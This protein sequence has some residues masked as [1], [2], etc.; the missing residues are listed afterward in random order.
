MFASYVDAV[1]T[2]VR[3]QLQGE[4]NPQCPKHSPH[5]NPPTDRRP[6]PPRS[7]SRRSASALRASRRSRAASRPRASANALRSS[8]PSPAIR[9]AACPSAPRRTSTR[10]SSA[11]APLRRAGRRL[12]TPSASASSCATTTW[13]SPSRRRS[14]T[15]SSSSPARRA[16]TP[17]RRSSTSPW[18]SRYYGNTA[19]EHLKPRRRAGVFPGL[20]ETWEYN[21]PVGVVGII[22]PWNYPLT[23]S[24]S[25]AI[26]ALAAGNAVVVKPDSQTPFTALWGFELLEQAGLPPGLVQVVTGSGSKIGPLMGD[27]ANYMMFTGQHEDRSRRR[28]AGGHAT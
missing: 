16:A 18:S 23:L 21:H 8:S 25:D 24:V 28:R 6:R 17:S 4:L 20:T 12:R 15:C 9:S 3:N 19:E 2:T 7:R 22:A 13:S 1:H 10:P 27:R 26:P 11:P 14:S 5:P